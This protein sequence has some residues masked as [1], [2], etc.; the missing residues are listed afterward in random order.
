MKILGW[1]LLLLLAQTI[2]LALGVNAQKDYTKLKAINY[3][4]GH[5]DQNDS[6]IWD[7]QK[8]C[9]RVILMSDFELRLKGVNYNIQREE[10][11]GEED[12]RSKGFKMNRWIAI[13]NSGRRCLLIIYQST[14]THIYIQYNNRIFGFNV[15]LKR[16]RNDN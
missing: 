14:F 7:T 9:N 15:I 2:M 4:D 8:K 13:D 11:L 5:Y 3:F 16:K 12:N 6:I 1:K 10:Y